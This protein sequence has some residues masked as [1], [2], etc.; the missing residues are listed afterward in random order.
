MER[1]TNRR[2]YCRFLRAKN[3][4][5]MLEGDDGFWSGIED[6]ATQ[7]W[8]VKTGHAFGPDSRPVSKVD[9]TEVWG[10]FVKEGY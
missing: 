6:P 7:Y 3:S 2:L 8:C 10:C 9:C 1:E 5:G 4:F